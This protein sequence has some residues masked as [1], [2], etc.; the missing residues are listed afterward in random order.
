MKNRCYSTIFRLCIILLALILSLSS[1]ACTAGEKD[2]ELIKGHPW[3]GKKA[4]PIE[5]NTLEGTRVSLADYHGKKYVVL[6]FAAS[7]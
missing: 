6:H 7:W 1:K 3:I 5:L 2:S 4:P